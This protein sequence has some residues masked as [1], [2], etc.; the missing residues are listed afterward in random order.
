MKRFLCGL[1]AL[2]LLV[3][4]AGKVKADYVFTTLDVNLAFGINDAGQ[5]VGANNAAGFLFSGG[6]YTTIN[7]PSSSRQSTTTA[8]GIN[9]AGQIVGSYYDGNDNSTH[10]FLL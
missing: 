5:I 6:I 10:G 4:R 1:T 3:G 8:Y 7:V 2:C 9:N